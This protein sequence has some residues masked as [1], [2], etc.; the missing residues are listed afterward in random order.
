MTSLEPPHSRKRAISVIVPACNEADRIGATVTALWACPHV[1][2]VVVIDDGSRDGTGEVAAAAGAS[3][4]R[5]PRRCGKGAA[6]QSGIGYARLPYVAFIDGDIGDTAA[7]LPS[8]AEPVLG[9]QADVT[10]ALMPLPGRRA[11]FGLVTGLARWAVLRYGGLDL[12]NPLCGQRVM[13]RENALKLV[14]FAPGYAIETR[15]AIQFGRFGLRVIEVPVEMTH[16]RSGR[17]LRGLLHRAAQLRDVLREC[18]YWAVRRPP[19]PGRP[20]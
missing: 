10:I 16:R 11:G 15:A 9:G 1:G 20:E 4:H 3:V 7:A 8:L 2:Q 12:S 14:P 19:K 5:H 13:S 18:F 17:D 6:L